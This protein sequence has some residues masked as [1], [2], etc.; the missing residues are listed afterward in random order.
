M[1]RKMRLKQ[2]WASVA[3]LFCVTAS[4]LTTLAAVLAYSHLYGLD[5]GT[6]RTAVVGDLFCI[7]LLL[8]LPFVFW[9]AAFVMVLLMENALWKTHEPCCAKPL[10]HQ[11]AYR[12]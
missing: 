7:P 9:L 6:G 2:G 4:I 8:T 5:C 1:S 11:N 3:L 12:I 10:E